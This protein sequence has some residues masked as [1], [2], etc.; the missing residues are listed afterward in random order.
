MPIILAAVLFVLAASGLARGEYQVI[1]SAIFAVHG[2]ASAPRPRPR[3][4]Y[5]KDGTRNI[6]VYDGCGASP[7]L[8]GTVTYAANVKR[9]PAKFPD[10]WQRRGENGDDG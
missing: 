4:E 3:I 2:L 8:L 9:Q 6:K 1:L 5:V 10:R 7:T